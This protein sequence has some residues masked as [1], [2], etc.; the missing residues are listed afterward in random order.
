MGGNL[1]VQD[2]RD[3][4]SKGWVRRMQPWLQARAD[5][6]R[7]ARLSWRLVAFV[8]L[9]GL[10]TIV[11]LIVAWWPAAS[12]LG[13]RRTHGIVLAAQ[14]QAL[15]VGKAYRPVIQYRYVVGG[16]QHLGTTYTVLPLGSAQ[17][18]KEWAES[19]I[20]NHVPGG[21]CAVHYDPQD[22]A[23]SVLH[24]K[25]ELELILKSTAL[26]LMGCAAVLLPGCAL[27]VRARQRLSRAAERGRL[28]VRFGIVPV[29]LCLGALLSS[30]GLFGVALWTGVAYVR[31]AEAWLERAV[32]WSWT[33]LAMLAL[34]F[35]LWLLVRAI[36]HLDGHAWSVGP[37]GLCWLYR[38]GS[39]A[40][41]WGDV[42]AVGL[43]DY[44]GEGMPAVRLR[45]PEAFQSML[46]SHE[47]ALSELSVALRRLGR[48]VRGK[49][50]GGPAGEMLLPRTAGPAAVLDRRQCG[51][52]IGFLW[53]G[54][55]TSPA[56]FTEALQTQKE[57]FDSTRC[58]PGL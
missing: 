19:V 32:A 9:I 51:Y 25:P 11:M 33:I 2:M 8:F 22:P 37:H 58:L 29:V 16:V 3:L 44:V 18:A 57:Q 4:Q 42:E 47:G 1:A 10:G 30:S 23:N 35:V 55:P 45:N 27:W 46:L 7:L 49:S 12:T 20:R 36:R 15:Q 24:W 6:W 38:G 14:V 21:T 50:A 5:P 53:L 43:L 31:H 54:L 13:Y 34:A 40:V 28:V 26:L 41:P 39:Y 48:L 17:G 52:D 56:R